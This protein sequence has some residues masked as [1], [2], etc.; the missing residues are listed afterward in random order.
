MIKLHDHRQLTIG[1]LTRACN[2]FLH[3]EAD[4][5]WQVKEAEGD[6][7]REV[8]CQLPWW[9]AELQIFNLTENRGC[10]L[11][12]PLD[13]P[14]GYREKLRG[15]LWV[16]V[17]AHLGGNT[18]EAHEQVLLAAANTEDP[19]KLGFE[20]VDAEDSAERFTRLTMEGGIQVAMEDL[21]TGERHALV[22]AATANV[23]DDDDYFDGEH[24]EEWQRENLDEEGRWTGPLMMANMVDDNIDLCLPGQKLEGNQMAISLDWWGNNPAFQALLYDNDSEEGEP[25]VAVRYDADGK[26][27][28]VFLRDPTR[29]RLVSDPMYRNLHT[30]PIRPHSPWQEA[31][32]AE[33]KDPDTAIQ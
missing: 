22:D 20:I 29:I 11:P 30:I 7:D 32:D 16:A 10:L 25:A 23:P 18:V 5:A 6:K 15:A 31:R 27:V 21:I 4:T 12:P 14:H 9:D 28:E 8:L 19:F 26:V 3:D 17:N 33:P 2:L 24:L 13:D 1:Y